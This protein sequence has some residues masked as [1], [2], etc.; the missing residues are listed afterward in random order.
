MTK[1]SDNV[2]Y[3]MKTLVLN[4]YFKNALVWSMVRPSKSEIQ[5]IFL[6]EFHIKTSLLNTHTR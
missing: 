3:V 1:W 5:H 2:F 6:Y 4:S